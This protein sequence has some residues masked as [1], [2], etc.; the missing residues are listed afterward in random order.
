VELF[1]RRRVV[2]FVGAAWMLSVYP[3]LSTTSD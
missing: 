1:A 3:W 2:I